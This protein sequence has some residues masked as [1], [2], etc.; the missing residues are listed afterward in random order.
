MMYELRRVMANRDE[1]CQLIGGIE[2][3]EAFF[4][5]NGPRAPDQALKHGAGSERQAK[6]VVMA[7]SMLVPEPKE[8]EKRN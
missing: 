4:V 1:K 6:V 5:V 8:G 2:L 3:N 7:E